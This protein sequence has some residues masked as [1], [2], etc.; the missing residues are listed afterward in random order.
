MNSPRGSSA[1]AIAIRSVPPRLHQPFE[2]DLAG[3]FV[4]AHHFLSELRGFPLL[5]F[6]SAPGCR[7]G[8]LPF[9]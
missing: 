5:I 7:S 1:F 8:R 9:D 2:S 3:A 6:F 4:A